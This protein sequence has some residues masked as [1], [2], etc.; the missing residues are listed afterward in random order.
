MSLCHI[1]TP[2]C[3]QFAVYHRECVLL[4]CTWP[5]PMGTCKHS[6]RQGRR[7]ARNLLLRIIPIFFHGQP[8][9]C[10]RF[11]QWRWNT[12]P[13]QRTTNQRVTYSR[14]SLLHTINQHSHNSPFVSC[15]HL[16]T[17]TPKIPWLERNPVR[18]YRLNNAKH[19]TDFCHSQKATAEHPINKRPIK[20][21][22]SSIGLTWNN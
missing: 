18:F 5:S 7:T 20:V 14:T 19:F 16:P 9:V 1:K 13:S 6:R 11:C 4:L 3:T 15:Q 12:D 21:F 10:N 17:R 22:A 2:L 8:T